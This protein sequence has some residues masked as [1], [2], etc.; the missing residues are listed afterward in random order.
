[1]STIFWIDERMNSCHRGLIQL[2]PL[3]IFAVM[4]RFSVGR[5]SGR[6][7]EAASSELVGTPFEPCLA[8]MLLKEAATVPGDFARSINISIQDV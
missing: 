4:L 7:L 1:M 6:R 2:K 5:T 3:T 8:L